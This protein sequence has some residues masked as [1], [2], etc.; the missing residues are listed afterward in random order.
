MAQK[1]T[2]QTQAPA[3]IERLPAVMRRT[4][5]SR[6]SIY[7]WEGEGKFPKRIKLGERAAGWR[8][9]DIDAWIASRVGVAQ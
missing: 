5:A 4:G 8:S 2:N 1:A 6:S 3:T 9:S 7:R